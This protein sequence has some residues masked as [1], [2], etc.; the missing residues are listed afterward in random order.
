MT[1]K[2]DDPDFL[3]PRKDRLLREHVH[4]TYKFRHKLHEPT[5]CPR[6]G[7]VYHE[8]RWHWAGAPP[9][10][11]RQLCPACHRVQDKYPAGF[12]NVS[13][14]FAAQHRQE[15]ISVA[16]SEE[17]QAMAEHPLER[18]IAIEEHGDGLLITTT[19]PHLARGIGEALR[20]AYQGELDFHYVEETDFLRVSW[21]R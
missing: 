6:C 12:V 3:P 16:R 2:T 20:H 7:A 21:K 14:P 19:N 9:D 13:G 15:I 4:D 17:K 18:I 5:V 1:D 8:G 11:H 10:A